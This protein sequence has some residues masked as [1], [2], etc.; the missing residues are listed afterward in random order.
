[1]P[2]SL[3]IGLVIGCYDGFFGP[4]AGTFLTLA[5]TGLCRFD[6]LTAAGNTKVANATSNLAS[7]VTFALGGKVLWA[8][9]ILG[10]YVGA[11]LALKGGAKV[12]R[13]MFFVVLTLL[14]V[15]LVWDL[16]A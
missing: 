1:M 2:L 11:G 16:L 7:L 15:R 8:V 3:A 9:G 5:F 13:P 10:G 6:L 12:I 14:V 4:G